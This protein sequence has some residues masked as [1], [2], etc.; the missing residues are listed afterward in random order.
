M[1]H[2]SGS[3]LFHKKSKSSLFSKPSSGEEGGSHGRKWSLSSNASRSSSESSQVRYNPLSLHPPLSLNT[4]PKLTEHDMAR[5]E[6]DEDRENR[7][8]NQTRHAND[9]IQELAEYSPVKGKNCYF[10]RPQ[11]GLYTHDQSSQWPLKDWPIPPGLAKQ[12]VPSTETSPFTHPVRPSRPSGH[13][14]RNTD[15]MDDNDVFVKRGDWKRRGIV[16]HLDPQD[17]DLQEQHFEL[18]E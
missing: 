16:F 18:P 14:R 5:Y 17:A 10:E 1:V 4:S 3:P 9:H 8:F 15:W 6:E 2:I 12:D 13:Q 7:F 11:G